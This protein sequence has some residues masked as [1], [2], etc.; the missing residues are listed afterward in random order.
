MPDTQK[1]SD[2]K[3]GQTFFEDLRR[4]DFFKN[5]K[6][7]FKGLKEFYIDEGHQKQLSDM[8][9][10]KRWFFFTVWLFKSLFFKL[11]P[12]RR[13]LI[14]AGVIFLF[15]G[16]NSGVSTNGQVMLF[17]VILFFVLMLE[18]KDKMLARSELE[19]GRSVQF[20]L[21]PEE[22]PKVSGW[23]IWL[24]TTPANDVGGDLVDF[25]K[26]DNARYGL[27]LGD[28]AG[29][30]LGAALFMA[31][32]QATIRALAP[33]YLKL[34]DLASKINQIFHR[35]ATAN[36]FASL[37]YLVLNPDSNEI[38]LLNAGHFP[39]YIIHRDCITEDKKGDPALGIMKDTGFK[40]HTIKIKPGEGL[41]VYSDGVTEAMNEQEQFFGDARLQSIL[42]ESTSHSA[43][44]T[45]QE[46]LRKIHAFI[47]DASLTD[48]LSMIILYRR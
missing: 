17:V 18:L 21:M 45:G 16:G 42:Q 25:L 22:T 4:G 19:A 12:T 48:D 43:K 2:P 7:D 44:E 26:I 24:F 14:V 30:G 11:T 6:R 37:I 8:N 38:R 32:L 33:D 15:L 13:L 20:A 47:G 35:D 10:I 28:V 5:I 36:K 39:P 46:I 23:D 29:K 9:R 27:A 3:V 31:K 41:C 34:T 40:E 1:N